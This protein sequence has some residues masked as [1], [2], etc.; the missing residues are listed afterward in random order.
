MPIGPELHV[1]VYTDGILGAGERYGQ[2]FDA[3][4]FVREQVLN[5]PSG[6]CSRFI[7]DSLLSRAV[8]L[9]RGRPCDDITVVVVSVAERQQ[10]DNIRRLSVRFPI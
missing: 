10:D 5:C 8:E 3:L 9:D 6:T 7:A 2:Q 1:I 4:P